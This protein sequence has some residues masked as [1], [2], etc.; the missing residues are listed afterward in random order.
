MSFQNIVPVIVEH[1]LRFE[2]ID[3]TGVCETIDF[4]QVFDLL[5]IATKQPIEVMKLLL[6]LKLGFNRI[7]IYYREQHERAKLELYDY[8]YQM[9]DKYSRKDTSNP[10]HGEKK[11]TIAAIE[12]AIKKEED[13]KRLNDAVKEIESYKMHIGACKDIIEQTLTA[14]QHFISNPL[15]VEVSFSDSD[16][17]LKK[18]SSL[19]AKLNEEDA[20]LI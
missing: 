9:Q 19:A 14:A 8:E 6:K 13:W 10:L 11:L 16:E 2:L 12:A 20:N 5:N 4:K 17:D 1:Q 18:I 15:E 3:S 7:Y